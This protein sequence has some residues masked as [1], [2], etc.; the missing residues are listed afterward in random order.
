MASGE[1]VLPTLSTCFVRPISNQPTRPGQLDAALP[2][3]PQHGAVAGRPAIFG[4]V[5]SD[6]TV[7]RRADALAAEAG[8]ALKAI[9]AAR[10]VAPIRVGF[11]ACRHAPNHGADA[12]DPGDHCALIRERQRE[13]IALAKTRAG[14]VQRYGLRTEPLAAMGLHGAAVDSRAGPVAGLPPGEPV[15]LPPGST[16]HAKFDALMLANL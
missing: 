13:G 3:R 8:R 12:E 5:A 10:A 14:E 7:S 4:P 9:D 11:A 2:A 6:P 16:G 15:Q 1:S